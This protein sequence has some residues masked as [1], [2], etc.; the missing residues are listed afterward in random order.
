M[1]E[2]VRVY[3]KKGEGV[4]IVIKSSIPSHRLNIPND[5]NKKFRYNSI[6]L[7]TSLITL[8]H[9]KYCSLLNNVDF[10]Q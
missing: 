2:N 6:L 1:T 3:L 5:F 10:N 8:L 9:T 4:L 7:S